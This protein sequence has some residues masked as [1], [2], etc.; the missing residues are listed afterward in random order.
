MLKNNPVLA[1]KIISLAAQGQTQQVIADELSISQP[2]V[3]RIQKANQVLIR[4]E[5]QK[6]LDILPDIV[7]NDIRE[8]QDYF[9]ISKNLSEQL[10]NGSTSDSQ[11]LQRFCEFVNSKITDIK[12]SIGMYSAHSPGLVFQQLNIFNSVQT[13]LNPQILQLLQGVN[14][15]SQVD[16][17]NIIDAEVLSS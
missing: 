16:Y 13:S 5:A 7:Q 15:Q 8:I 10:K 6:Y 11:Q 4:R 9:T 14:S 17:D 12:R 3:Q 2:T 1:T